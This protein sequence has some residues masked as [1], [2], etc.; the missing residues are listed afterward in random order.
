MAFW[1]DIQIQQKVHRDEASRLHVIIVGG[2]LGGLGAAIASLL[3][4]HDVTVLE[5]ASNI[6]EVGAGIQV[7]PNSARVLFSWGLKDTLEPYATK[8]TQCNFIGWRGNHLSEMDYVA[9]TS[10]TGAPFWDFYRMNLHK[11]LLDRAVELGAKLVTNA[12]ATDFTVNSDQSTSTVTCADGR[13]FEADL[14]VGADGINSNL[15]EAFLGRDDPPIPTGDLAYRLMLNT[16]EMRKDPDLREFVEKP[17]VNY[18]VGPGK[19]AVN[20]VLRGK[21]ATGHDYT[22]DPNLLFNM[23]LLVP[24]D[25]PAGANTLEG[26]IEEM[27]AHFADWDPR[28][29]KLLSM[30]DSVLKWRLM[31]RPGLE[32]TWSHPSGTFTMLGDAVHA[33][34][35]YLAS[36]AGMALEDA[37]VLGLCLG[38]LEGKSSAEKRKALAVYEACR[39]ERTEEV[40]RR[41]TYNQWIYHLEDGD[42]QRDRD[43]K[44]RLFGHLDRQWLSEKNPILPAANET[45]N[46]PFPWRYHGVARWLLT[47][48][49]WK[50][51]A[52]RWSQS[53]IPEAA[54][55]EAA[56]L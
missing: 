27:R 17:Q 30:C 52:A 15:R 56:R 22:S 31:I 21:A 49:M 12:R 9:Y 18:W 44:F 45:G 36:G 35:P 48:D 47:Y 28:I 25:M 42:E 46:D 40:V 53:E 3:A 54:S 39:R 10:A 29:P 6:G 2:G 43:A 50:D 13:T 33:T 32:P 14:V 1:N 19:H 24:D 23:V 5:A 16:E 20:Y 7:L 4:G 11:C 37:G 51:V 26:N 8:P 34:L 55:M 41:G 38:R